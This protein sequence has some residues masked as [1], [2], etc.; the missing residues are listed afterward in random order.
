LAPATGGALP[1]CPKC[2]T[3]KS[4]IR[5]KEEYGGGFVC[6]AKKNNGCGQKWK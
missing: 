1:A 3:N 5:G 6:F 4:T 2:G